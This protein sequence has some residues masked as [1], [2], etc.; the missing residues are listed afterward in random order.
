[1]IPTL[2]SGWVT[3]QRRVSSKFW[4]PKASSLSNGRCTWSWISPRAS[5]CFSTEQT[6]VRPW[7]S[8]AIF[9]LQQ[10]VIR[11]GIRFGLLK[12]HGDSNSFLRSI[13][14]LPSPNLV[15]LLLSSYATT[16]C[17]TPVYL[18]RERSRLDSAPPA[19]LNRHIRAVALYYDQSKLY[20]RHDWS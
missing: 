19:P 13:V 1:M 14:H 20:W 12:L 11:L 10:F 6:I 15:L 16:S 5:R 2:L 17:K 8:L 18:L 3:H 4:G 9:K 7:P